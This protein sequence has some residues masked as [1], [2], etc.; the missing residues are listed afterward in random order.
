MCQEKF[1][2]GLSRLMFGFSAMLLQG[3]RKKQQLWVVPELSAEL[4]EPVLHKDAS[5]PLL[6]CPAL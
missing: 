1:K 6:P 5:A 2:L 3:G 4:A